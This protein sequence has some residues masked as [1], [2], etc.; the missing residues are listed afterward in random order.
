MSSFGI[1]ISSNPLY[2]P[3]SWWS[4][5]RTFITVIDIFDFGCEYLSIIRISWHL[6]FHFDIYIYIYIYIYSNVSLYFW[7]HWSMPEIRRVFISIFTKSILISSVFKTY[8]YETSFHDIFLFQMM[9]LRLC[10]FIVNNTDFRIH[11]SLG[12]RSQIE[13]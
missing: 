3:I 11:T 5:L 10:P 1:V 6:C 2:F 12:P 8:I 13:F 4:R 7:Y 9:I